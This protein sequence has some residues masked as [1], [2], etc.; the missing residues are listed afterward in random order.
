LLKFADDNKFTDTN[1]YIGLLKTRSCT[2]YSTIIS[3]TCYLLVSFTS[4]NS[5]ISKTA[6]QGRFIITGENFYMYAMIGLV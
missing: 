3:V 1:S 4:L 5:I 2:N 6:G